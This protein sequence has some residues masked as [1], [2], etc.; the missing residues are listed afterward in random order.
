[1][2]VGENQL[3]DKGN[4]PSPATTLYVTGN[5][6]SSGKSGRADLDELLSRDFRFLF[7]LDQFPTAE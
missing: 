7:S 2:L 4:P 6:I 1:M 3:E 5:S